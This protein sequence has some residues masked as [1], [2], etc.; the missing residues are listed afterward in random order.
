MIDLTHASYIGPKH[1]D[2]TLDEL[3]IELRTL[4]TAANGFVVLDGGLH[5]RGVGD[6]PDWHSLMRMWTGNEALS[7]I[8]PNVR[9][10]DIPFAEDYLGDQF[11]LR[12]GA[13][14]RLYGETGET[15][16]IEIGLNSFLDSVA[17]NP[18]AV[19]SLN[20]LRQ[21]QNEGGTLEP[22]KLLSVYPPLCTSEASQGVSLR[23]IPV[24]ERIRF[25]ADF[26]RQITGHPEGASV[27][28]QIT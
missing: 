16:E 15:E 25:L 8:Y 2:G 12:N 5:V 26:A 3:P 23:P 20:L 10:D 28:I 17:D 9:P 21:F 27:R 14:V 22:G 13:V 19:L 24:L 11:L 1:S 7:T 4:L 6:I 18:D